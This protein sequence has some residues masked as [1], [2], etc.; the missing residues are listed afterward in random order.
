M[1]LQV[2]GAGTGRT[3]TSSLRQALEFLLG[4]PCYHMAELLANPDHVT[5]WLEGALDGQPDWQR[6]LAKYGAGVDW[7]VAA[8]WPELSAAFPNAL[9]LLS[10]RP[11]DEWWESAS[12]TIYAPR[13]RKEGSLA[14]LSQE[15]S[16]TR[17]P[18]H[19]IIHDKV[20]SMQLYEEWNRSVIEKAPADRLVIW[21]VGDGWQPLCNALDLPIPEIPF[22]HKNTKADFIRRLVNQ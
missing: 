8:F 12:K 2:I 18:I 10:K 7:P 4:Q 21:N 15:L 16:R 13:N 3:G 5:F 1:G 17:F 14:E 19:P 20:A 6:A 11:A 22:P 9:I